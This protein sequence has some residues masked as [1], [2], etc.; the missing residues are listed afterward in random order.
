MVPLRVY[1]FTRIKSGSDEQRI[2][3]YNFFVLPDGTLT[4]EI[5]DVYEQSERLALSS[6]GVAQVQVVTEGTTSIEDGT[7]AIRELLEGM[8]ELLRALRLWR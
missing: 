4:A 8:P 7:A 3:V 6:L 5:R 1:T 2:R